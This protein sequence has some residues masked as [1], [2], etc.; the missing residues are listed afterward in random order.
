MS[1]TDHIK[2]RTLLAATAHK[3]EKAFSQLYQHASAN[4][5]AVALRIL[6]HEKSAE[7]ALQDAFV[8]IWHNAS[9]FHA[10]KG[11][12]MAWMASI[13]RYRALDIIRRQ[14]SAFKNAQSLN[15]QSVDAA[16]IDV[17]DENQPGP[18]ASLMQSSMAKALMACIDELNELQRDTIILAFYEGLTHE[19]LAARITQPLGTVKSWVRRGLQKIKLC[20]EV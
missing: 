7:D 9:E 19:Q 10:E 12:P 2:L 8:N 13:V 20:L 14:K 18:M 16:E 15:T 1:D 6:K 3:D 4:L 11:L 5:F 17:H